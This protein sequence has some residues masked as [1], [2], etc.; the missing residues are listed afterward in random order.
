VIEVSDELSEYPSLGVGDAAVSVLEDR[1]GDDPP[2]RQVVNANTSKLSTVHR[3]RQVFGSSR[4]LIRDC[5]DGVETMVSSHVEIAVH[6]F[7]GQFGSARLHFNERP[8]ALPTAIDE[9][10]A[11]G[12]RSLAILIFQLDLGVSRGTGA[13]CP[14]RPKE[15]MAEIRDCS[16]HGEKSRRSAS[17]LFFLTPDAGD[18]NQPGTMP[19]VTCT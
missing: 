12:N 17:F 6:L 3:E 19:V 16:N 8:P 13:R 9:N 14:Q 2:P 7:A 11:V 5:D 15:C 10:C 18:G 4:Y 1:F